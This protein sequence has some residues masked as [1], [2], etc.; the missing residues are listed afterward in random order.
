[1]TN[2][3][4]WQPKLLLNDVADLSGQTVSVDQW[5][6]L[7]LLHR[8]QGDD[9]ANTLQALLEEL[10]STSWSPTNGALHIVSPTIYPAG[11]SNVAGQLAELKDHMDDAESKLDLLEDLLADITAGTISVFS[12]NDIGN[13]DV[14]DAHPISAI[15][16]LQAA[17]DAGY[18]VA[19]IEYSE[20]VTLATKLANMDGVISGLSSGVVTIDH[21]DVL[22]RTV[23]DAHPISAITGLQA[24]LDLKA[25]ASALAGYQTKITASTT[26]PSGGSDGDIWIVYV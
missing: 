20:G 12:H 2:L 25:A 6:N 22:G 18:A 10:Y 14:A 24:A 13:R 17:L 1:M 21:E 4:A 9:T 8:T 3:S 23:A 26:G 16:G 11:S 15:T 5:N 7:W 19:D